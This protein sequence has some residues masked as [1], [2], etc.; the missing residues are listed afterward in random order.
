MG[1]FLPQNVIED[2]LLSCVLDPVEG[3]EPGLPAVT[4]ASIGCQSVRE[5]QGNMIRERLEAALESGGGRVALCLGGVTSL[6]SAFI[7]DL[8]QVSD[9]CRVKGGR[10]VLYGV[11][12]VIRALFHAAGFDAKLEVADTRDEAVAMVRGEGRRGANGRGLGLLGRLM[13]RRAA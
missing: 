9:R 2:C 11:D 1:E 12:P 6:S 4:V 3:D 5:W 10:L 8:I 13:G 7:R